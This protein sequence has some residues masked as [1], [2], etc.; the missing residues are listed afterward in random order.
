VAVVIVTGASSGIGR[1]AAMRLGEE[2]AVPVLAARTAGPLEDTASEIR[3]LGSGDTA[4]RV[5][6]ELGTS[7]M[8]A[9]RIAAT[10]PIIGKTA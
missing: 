5:S 8:S 3:D 10:A 9:A 6:I 7:S 1:V 2:G 4:I